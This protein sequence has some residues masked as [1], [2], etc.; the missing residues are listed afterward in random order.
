MLTPLHR[1]AWQNPH[2]TLHIPADSRLMTATAKKKSGRP[3]RPRHSVLSLLSNMHL[4]L[5]VPSFARWPLQ[6]HF[7]ADDVH[8]VW[9]RWT[10]RCEG[11]LRE[12]LEVVL[13]PRPVNNLSDGV[14]AECGLGNVGGVEDEVI[15][16]QSKKR[17]FE[18][19]E[20]QIGKLPVD[21]ALLKTHVEK[22]KSVFDFEREGSCTVCSEDLEHDQG[23]Y[24][25]CPAADCEAVSHLTCLSRHFLAD[26]VQTSDAED[27]LV[28]ISGLCPSCGAALKWVDLVKELSLRMRGQKEVERLLKKPRVKAVK[29]AKK[30]VTPSQVII[31]SEDEE[32]EDEDVV[33]KQNEE[34]EAAVVAEYVEG[35]NGSRPL[36]D[37]WLMGDDNDD[38]FIS[39]AS[40]STLTSRPSPRK[41]RGEAK[42][43]AVD[44]I[45]EDSDWD[46]AE[47]LD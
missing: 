2:L 34:D 18:E 31:A 42:G 11:E 35:D 45:V 19:V 16:T 23:V 4:L 41:G 38:D 28:P 20:S 47:I 9:L 17:K 15:L 25:I 27:L 12:S 33:E 40:D 14:A 29:K 7:F 39:V 32:D 13:D 26:E 30:G 8:N 6:V 22:S 36:D 43:K 24:A 1:W 5:R 10:E 44:K 3:K 37:N 46:D 21:Y